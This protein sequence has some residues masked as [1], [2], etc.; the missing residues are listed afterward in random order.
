MREIFTIGHSNH[1]MEHFVGLLAAHRISAI[2]DVRSSPYSE[3]APQFN[4]EALQETLPDAGIEYVFLGRELGAR[5]AEEICYVDGQAKYGL[6]KKLPLF[7]RGLECVFEGIEQ[8]IVSLMCSEADPL[9]CHR[10]ILVCHELRIL[11]PG[12]KIIHILEDGSLES[13]EEAEERLIR[14][15]KLQ[16]ELFGDLSSASGLVEKAYA[17][18]AE[19]IAYKK[20]PT[21]CWKLIAGVIGF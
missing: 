16:P 3:Y 1:T 5:R 19:R 21:A 6:I 2:A 9:A 20:T 13:Q 4:G 14:L 12:I 15:H 8:Y 17:L 18:Q 10:T 11:R 7:R